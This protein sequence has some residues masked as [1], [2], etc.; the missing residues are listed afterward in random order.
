[1]AHRLLRDYA[2]QKIWCSPTQDNQIKLSSR[3][4]VKAGGEI[5]SI[6]VMGRVIP[7]PSTEDYY[8]VYQVGGQVPPQVLGLLPKSPEWALSGWVSFKDAVNQ[9]ELFCNLYTALGITLPLHQAYYRYTQ[10]NAFVFCVKMDEKLP[11]DLMAEQVYLRLYTN[12]FYASD[13]SNNIAQTTKT[14]GLTIKNVQH[15]QQIANEVLACR[16]WPGRVFC[17]K[18]GSLVDD[19]NVANL[20]LGDLVEYLYDPSVR[21][22]VDFQVKDL[23]S[24]TSILDQAYKYL[25]HYPDEGQSV[26]DYVD[27]IDVYV[28]NTTTG[29]Y[30]GRYYNQNELKSLRNVTHRDFSLAVDQ[31][32]TIAEDLAKQRTNGLTEDLQSYHIVIYIRQ[33]GLTRPLVYDNYRLFE[34]YKLSDKDIKAALIGLDSTMPYWNAPFL[35]NCGYVRLFGE[36]Y[37][38]ISQSMIEDAL[39]Y[40]AISRILGDT[41]QTGNN[42]GGKK[43]FR[44]PPAMAEKSTVYEYNEAGDL[45]GYYRS[46]YTD[47]YISVNADCYMIEAI[48]GHG[49][50]SLNGV[51][52][53]NNI[54]L[55]TKHSY[56]VYFCYLKSD[57]Q[58][59][60][61]WI[62]I[63]GDNDYYTVVNDRLVWN[64]TITNYQLMVKTDQFFYANQLDIVPV[65][66]TLY[67][68]IAELYAGQNQLMAVP[69][70]FLDVWLNGKSLIYGLGYFIVGARVYIVDREHTKQPFAASPQ[71]ITVRFYGLA[72]VDENKKPMIRNKVDFGFVQHGVLSNDYEYDV[73]DDRVLRIT[74]R[75]QL[76]LRDQITFSEQHDG[77]DQLNPVNGSPYEIKPIIVPTL[78]YTDEKT[79]SLLKKSETIDSAVQSYMTKKLPQPD[80]PAVSAIPN[81]YRLVSPF[82]AHIINDLYTGQFDYTKI[83]KDLSDNE[84]IDICQTYEHLLAF[85]P[86]NPDN[87]VDDR[88]VLICPHA[89]EESIGLGHFSYQFIRKVITLYGRGLVPVSPYLTIDLGVN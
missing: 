19:L 9:L 84:V 85:D 35:E 20:E 26:I 15:M 65:A 78:D 70:G 7:L 6:V 83:N 64:D 51:Y 24:F 37:R 48:A 79:Y 58:P 21:T 62:D 69:Q 34:L 4:I 38:N 71:R 57:G 36:S 61:N 86:I 87:P 77:I 72:D 33:S 49:S 44:L 8:Q 66:G 30:T 88:Y 40:N 13:E 1:M 55:P 67:F 82:I 41:P 54:T 89:E 29:A 23:E 74:V 80:R 52:G 60:Q 81:R 47:L 25:L 53:T 68:D 18:N 39:G 11:S 63:T 10:D 59:S 45:L 50:N 14:N 5:G 42:T 28:V 43:S 75:G 73:R 16:S 3:R 22:V 31:F 12:E 2:L 32:R 76:R 46:S 27:D 17:F 56:C